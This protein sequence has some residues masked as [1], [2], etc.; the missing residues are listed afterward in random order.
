MILLREQSLIEQ[1]SP[2]YHCRLAPITHSP[3]SYLCQLELS[4]LG[5]MPAVERLIAMG[6]QFK[7]FQY[8]KLQWRE[9]GGKK[10]RRWF[11][12]PS[13]LCLINWEGYLLNLFSSNISIHSIRRLLFWKTGWRDEKEPHYLNSRSLAV[14]RT[15]TDL[16]EGVNWLSFWCSYINFYAQ[17]INGCKIAKDIPHAVPEKACLYSQIPFFILLQLEI[18][19]CK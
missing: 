7:L 3:L 14:T 6:L 4:V 12:I 2:I 13:S 16:P 8:R 15:G 1:S 17:R 11:V 10:I 9:E 18:V 5:K 19:H